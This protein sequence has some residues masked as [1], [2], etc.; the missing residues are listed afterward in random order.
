MLSKRFLVSWLSSS[1]VMFILFYVWHGVC[2]TDFNRLNYPK[3]IF[4][5]FAVFVYLVIGFV[6]AKAIEVKL[7]DQYF[8][9]KPFAKGAISGAAL[10]FGIFIFSTVVGVSFSTGN[11]LDNLVLDVA[12][13][14]VE[15]TLGGLVVG[16]AHFFVFDP[17][18]AAE[19]NDQ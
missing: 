4:L 18:V 1:V 14:V 8:K 15:Q 3:E 19:E 17:V 7:L 12:W 5:V 2:L 10:G 13:Q 11:K 6:S 9:R 16:L